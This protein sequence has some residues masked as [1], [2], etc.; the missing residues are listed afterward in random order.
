MRR[1]R[2]EKPGPGASSV[3][4]YVRDESYVQVYKSEVRS[5]TSCISSHQ[6]SSSSIE[7]MAVVMVLG[8]PYN[9]G[10]G[11]AET[12]SVLSNITWRIQIEFYASQQL[13]TW[14]SVQRGELYVTAAAL[15][16]SDKLPLIV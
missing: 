2:V 11:M 12:L 8:R 14:S 7:L 9:S 16:R 10:S 6:I 5:D 4:Q 15:V 1:S 13:I 3:Y